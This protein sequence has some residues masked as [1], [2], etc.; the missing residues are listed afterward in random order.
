MNKKR[1]LKLE[2][3]QKEINRE[4]ISPKVV[5]ESAEGF[6]TAEGKTL[7]KEGESFFF[8]DGSIYYEPSEEH[9]DMVELFMVKYV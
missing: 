7:V 5:H 9:T 3:R 4:W 2:K 6:T 1:V 8:E